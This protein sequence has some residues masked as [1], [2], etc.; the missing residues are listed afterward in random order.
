MVDSDVDEE[1]TRRGAAASVSA[2]VAPRDAEG[3]AAKAADGERCD[4]AAA[5]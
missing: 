5:G 1:V 2:S 4:G 3:G